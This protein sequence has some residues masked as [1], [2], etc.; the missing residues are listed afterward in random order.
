MGMPHGV[1]VDVAYCVVV[2]RKLD[3]ALPFG[4]DAGTTRLFDFGLGVSTVRRF[5]GSFLPRLGNV[6]GTF[7]Q[8]LPVLL[9]LVNDF[10]VVRYISWIGHDPR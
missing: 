8:I 10:L 6:G 5:T 3:E 4:V 1:D 7:G 2:V 9:L